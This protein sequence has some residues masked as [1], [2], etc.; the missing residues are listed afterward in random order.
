MLSQMG[1]KVRVGTNEH[2]RTRDAVEAVA[3]SIAEMLCD[4]PDTN[5]R[6]PNSDWSVGEAAAHLA[7]AQELFNKWLRG[8]SGPFADAHATTFASV[9]A[10]LLTEFDER[11]GARLAALLVDRTR[12]FLDESA[13]RPLQRQFFSP[14]GY[15]DLP[16]LTSY[17]LVHL[18]MH[19]CPIAKALGEPTPLEPVHTDLAIL[20]LKAVMPRVFD[21]EAVRG[22][23]S[24]LQVRIRGGRR[25]AIMF[26]DGAVTVEDAPTRRVDCY[27]SADPVALF[28]VAFGLAS[29]WRLIAQGKL[30]AWGL[31]PWLALRFKTYF[32]NP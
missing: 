26:D 18:L 7:T 16:T 3:G 19:G 9:N 17:M 6:I 24:C 15:M 23:K 32:P 27:L 1:Q 14:F 4:L 12:S 20:F 31:K 25:L 8:G 11:D 28:L 29:Q 22:L 10:G 5:V 30:M 21:K 2:Q 13:E